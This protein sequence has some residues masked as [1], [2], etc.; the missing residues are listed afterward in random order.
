MNF[1]K[2]SKGKLK[3]D[4]DY[5]KSCSE[6]ELFIQINSYYELLASLKLKTY[7]HKMRM[8]YQKAED[9]TLAE[10]FAKKEQNIS[11]R[12][13]SDD[14]IKELE[15]TLDFCILESSRFD[16]GVCFNS[17]GVV[18]KTQKFYN[19]YYSW[20]FYIQ[21]MDDETL[22]AYRKCRYEGKGLSQFQLKSYPDLE[23]VEEALEKPRIKQYLYS[24]STP[25]KN[26]RQKLA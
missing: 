17:N 22:L 12:M 18:E 25:I 2:V 6:I 24:N 9:L 10:F 15:E 20:N 26:I 7:Y 16:T 13:P 1:N 23:A 4:A 3:Y 14:E 19:W 8:L 21:N 11:E 5:I